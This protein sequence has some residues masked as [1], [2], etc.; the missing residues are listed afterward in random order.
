[1]YVLCNIHAVAL[2]KVEEILKAAADMAMDGDLQVSKFHPTDIVPIPDR[3]FEQEWNKKKKSGSKRV[4]TDY[5]RQVKAEVTA[6][7]QEYAREAKSI[8]TLT[9]T[10]PNPISTSSSN[11]SKP[12]TKSNHDP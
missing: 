9:L 8:V 6:M 7:D 3:V 5:V 1:M 11:P 12:D 10:N 4:A 2:E